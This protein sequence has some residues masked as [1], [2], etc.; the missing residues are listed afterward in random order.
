MVLTDTQVWET[1][2]RTVSPSRTGP[3]SGPT[4]PGPTPQP[5]GLPSWDAD[6]V[7]QNPG[8]AHS[9]RVGP[10]CAL[11]TAQRSPGRRQRQS[12]GIQD[13]GSS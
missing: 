10:D 3:P 13:L 8:K 7:Y 2:P 12:L 5:Q 9:L 4:G 6:D 11:M 1:P